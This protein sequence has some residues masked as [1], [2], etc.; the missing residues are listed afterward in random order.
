[1]CAGLESE[2]VVEMEY[3]KLEVLPQCGTDNLDV[4]SALFD[5][6]IIS[7][8]G[9]AS[10]DYGFSSFIGKVCVVFDVL[11]VGFQ[12]CARLWQID[13]TTDTCLHNIF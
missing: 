1:M 8:I 3:A 12:V 5:D 9:V 7:I 11:H 10:V 2:V 13:F 6:C 4:L